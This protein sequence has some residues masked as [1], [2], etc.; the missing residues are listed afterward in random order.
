MLQYASLLQNKKTPTKT[1]KY[2]LTRGC[3][4]FYHCQYLQLR[5]S[6]FTEILT[7]PSS[8]VNCQPL[9]ERSPRGNLL[10]VTSQPTRRG[11]GMLTIPRPFPKPLISCP[12]T[13]KEVPH[14]QVLSL[15]RCFL[16]LSSF[17]VH[18]VLSTTR[19][20]FISILS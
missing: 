20:F 19:S 15:K 16:L 7:T 14:L 13:F 1:V 3:Q 6:K 18:L 9:P 2:I 8:G 17:H 11:Q 4:T 12:L 5:P 10:P